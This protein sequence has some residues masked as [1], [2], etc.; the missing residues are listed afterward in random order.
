VVELWK[1]NR[2]KISQ[3]AA[4]K[5]KISRSVHTFPCHGLKRSARPQSGDKSVFWVKYEAISVG[6]G[7]LLPYVLSNASKER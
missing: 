3:G 7:P 1:E 2:A 4:K 5:G 6:L